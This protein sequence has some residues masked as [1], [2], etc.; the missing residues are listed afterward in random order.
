MVVDGSPVGLGESGAADSVMTEQVAKETVS[1]SPSSTTVPSFRDILA[2]G[3]GGSN[4]DEWMQEDSVECEEGDIRF[5]QGKHGLSLSFSA[6]YKKRLE[7]AWQHA[8]IVKLLGKSI[9]YKTLCARLQ[10]LWKP[11][12][13]VRVIDLDNEFYAVRFEKEA[14]YIH[15]LADGPWQI[16]IYVLTVQPWVTSF[17]ASRGQVSTTVVWVR[18]PNFPLS[19]YDK[20]VLL[21]LGNLVES[22]MKINENILKSQRGKFARVAVEVDLQKLLKGMVEVEEE[23]FLVMYEGLPTVCYECGSIFHSLASCPARVA[24]ERAAAVSSIGSGSGNT[25]ASVSMAS[26]PSPKTVGE[27]MNAPRNSRRRA[28]QQPA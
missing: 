24:R 14:D 7:K 13:A 5:V 18:F 9:G 4:P 10:S 11:T 8:V 1:S 20:N 16:M 21:A 17:R 6:D 19:W 12:G 22:A 26:N 2:R 27:W 28:W 23:E 15:A 25:T 3:G